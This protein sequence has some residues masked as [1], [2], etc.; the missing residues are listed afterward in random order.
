MVILSFRQ[1]FSNFF[2]YDEI[3]TWCWKSNNKRDLY[4]NFFSIF[5]CRRCVVN[6]TVVL[7]FSS[8]LRQRCRSL[9]GDVSDGP[10]HAGHGADGLCGGTLLIWSDL[11][12]QTSCFSVLIRC[13]KC[14]SGRIDQLW[15]TQTGRCCHLV[16]LYSITVFKLHQ[17]YSICCISPPFLMD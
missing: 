3:W 2:L 10:H 1:D 5:V 16:V 7:F 17:I 13:F 8:E 9:P 12:L 6:L 4:P 14:F 11:W 15:E